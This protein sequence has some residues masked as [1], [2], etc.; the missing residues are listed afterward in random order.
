MATRVVRR[1]SDAAI[2]TVVVF[3][4]LVI[5]IAGLRAATDVVIPFLLSIFLA[6]LCGPPL[7]KLQSF[8]MRR[9]W[10]M[11]VVLIGLAMGCLVAATVIGGTI[12]RFVSDWYLIYGP[13][14][15]TV[16]GQWNYWIDSRVDQ[17]PW[18]KDMRVDEIGDLWTSWVSPESVMSYFSGALRTVGGTLGNALTILLTTIFMLAEASGFPAKLARISSVPESSIASYQRIGTEINRYMGIKTLTSALTGLVI[19][20]A[21]ILL[22]VE[23]ALL[24]GLLAFLL[25]FIP[26]IG[27]ILAAIPAVLLSLLDQGLVTAFLVTI[28]YVAANMVI[29]NY[30]EPRW[31]GRGLDLST[32]VV[33]LSLLFWGWVF[34]PVG[35]LISVPLTMGVKIVLESSEETRWIAILLSGDA[36]AVNKPAE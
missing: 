10:A 8:G 31:M 1:Q 30:L 11:L 15:E 35:M 5:I 3:A 29:G 7:A 13:K 20:V 2:R 32:L 27:S 16:L 24:W 34:G 19:A 9:G 12:N 18:M 25:N 6:V 21:L 26:N 36:T 23:F 14:A 22:G 28:V 17:E 33:I 4:S